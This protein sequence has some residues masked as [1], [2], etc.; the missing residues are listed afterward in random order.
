MK[1]NRR[2]TGWV[3]SKK[4]VSYSRYERRF[5]WDFRKN[6][7][8]IEIQFPSSTPKLW[9]RKYWDTDS[10][11]RN[12]N[13]EYGYWNHIIV[14]FLWVVVATSRFQPG[15]RAYGTKSHEAERKNIAGL[16]LENIRKLH[17]P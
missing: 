6:G 4:R 2:Q 3:I 15:D 13:I 10:D 16:K 8:R 9:I 12:G 14:N 17:K 5:I 11:S 1:K 7:R